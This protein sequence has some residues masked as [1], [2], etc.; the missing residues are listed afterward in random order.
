MPLPLCTRFATRGRAPVH[1]GAVVSC[2]FV[3]PTQ[4]KRGRRDDDL[5]IGRRRH[6]KMKLEVSECDLVEVVGHSLDELESLV[7]A[8]HVAF[9]HPGPPAV[10]VADQEVLGRIVQNLLANALRLT[11]KDGE[12]RIGIVVENEQTR[13]FVTDSGPDSAE[14]RH[15]KLAEPCARLE[16]P[17]TARKAP[18]GLGLAFCKVAVEAHGGR[19][20]V[21][22]GRGN[23]STFWF[24]LPSRH[25]MV[26]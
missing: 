17:P 5:D 15:R 16:A 10:V 19:I 8:R 20:G 4:P 6:Y 25:P 21:D 24:T 12:I 18:S 1:T 22:R 23:G 9:E 14:E 2:A 11:P 3:L 13:V 26:E 7:G